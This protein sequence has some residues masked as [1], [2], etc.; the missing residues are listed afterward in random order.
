M[1]CLIFNAQ[2]TSGGSGECRERG[3]WVEGVKSTG[4]KGNYTSGGK[5]T[6]NDN[7]KM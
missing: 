2:I 7:V 1:E 6:Q 5:H 4:K 3:K